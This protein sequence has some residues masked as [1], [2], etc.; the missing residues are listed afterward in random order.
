M[1]FFIDHWLAI[2]VATNTA[3]LIFIAA[4]GRGLRD[5][6]DYLGRRLDRL[7]RA[8]RR[9]RLMAAPERQ[10]GVKMVSDRSLSVTEPESSPGLYARRLRAVND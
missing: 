1:A 10:A 7:D 5:R 4:E 3:L 9:G 8:L 2:L 6:Q